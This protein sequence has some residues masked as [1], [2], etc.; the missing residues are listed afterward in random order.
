MVRS[1]IISVL[2]IIP[3]LLAGLTGKIIANECKSE[4]LIIQTDPELAA[5]IRKAAENEEISTEKFGAS[6]DDLISKNRIEEIHRETKTGPN[7]GL[8]VFTKKLG[9]TTKLA[10]D[11]VDLGYIINVESLLNEDKN[12]ISTKFGGRIFL[13]VTR[14][15]FVT[16]NLSSS[17]ENQLN[18]WQIL[19]E[20]S[21]PDSTLMVL[22][23]VRRPHAPNTKPGK[24]SFY[25]V[26]FE[27]LETTEEDLAKFNLAGAENRGKA[28]AWLRD[29]GTFLHGTELDLSRELAFVLNIVAEYTG[30]EKYLG[31]EMLLK[32]YQVSTEGDAI[33]V[34][35]DGFLNASEKS[36]KRPD[37]PFYTITTLRNGETKVLESEG[38]AKG[39]RLVILA[40]PSI[41]NGKVDSYVRPDDPI[42]EGAS[43]VSHRIPM[44][45]MEEMHKA[46]SKPPI[47]SNP[48]PAVQLLSYLE[49]NGVPV[50]EDMKPRLSIFNNA[51]FLT[52]STEV[53][54]AVRKYF[55]EWKE[56]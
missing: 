25:E 32:L 18:R 55:K 14:K 23:Q 16:K 45:F 31:Y 38:K 3:V 4:I 7:G 52:A 29:R 44:G 47:N 13:S 10:D 15:L 26:R 37:Y 8:L 39:K 40:T 34:G 54:K 17:K 46:L 51:F 6:L 35:F 2:A 19:G 42:G 5:T 33:T 48:R 49:D 36:R 24:P 43:T 21:E 41:R 9:E 20:W 1:S 28:L 27:F 22:N 30:S 50:D 12:L 53:H 56:K 11:P